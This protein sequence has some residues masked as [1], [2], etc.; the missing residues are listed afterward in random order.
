MK[1]EADIIIIGA[2]P[3][4]LSAAAAAAGQGLEV[5][6]LD[7]QPSLGGQIYRNIE[8]APKERIKI[9]GKD[10]SRGKLLAERFRKSHAGYQG[11]TMVWRI[12]HDGRVCFSH[13]GRARQIQGEKIILATGAMERP[14]PFSGWTLPG[15]MGVGALDANFKSSGTVPEGPVVMAGSGPLILSAA[16]HLIRQGV[17]ITAILETTPTANIPASLAH[18][19]Q[20]L[21]RPDYLFKGLAMMAALKRA[22]IPIIRGVTSYK[23]LGNDQVDRVVYRTAKGPGE[24]AARVLVVHEGIIPRTDFSCQ[25]GLDHTWNPV[26]KYWHPK[27]NVFGKTRENAIYV[28]GDGAFVHGGISASLKGELAALDIAWDLKLV[29][30]RIKKAAMKRIKKKLVKEFFPRPFVDALYKPR[31]GLYDL[32]DDTLVCRCEGVRAGDIRGALD[33]G[34]RE[35]N[36]IKALTRCGMGPCQGRMCGPALCELIA[37][38]TGTDISQIP[39]LN[40]RPPVRNISLEELAGIDLLEPVV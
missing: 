36:E 31:P 3:A 2:G 17:E 16:V 12:D 4:G 10:Y 27:T 20:A 38:H 29:P 18:V 13:E 22:G 24:L 37:H 32:E 15:V 23:A 30:D 14:V 21:K 25:A 6:V 11:N 33:Q 28:A 40:I 7:E 26:Q 1:T 34:C 39:V 35:P 9:L 19:G 8:K 5:L